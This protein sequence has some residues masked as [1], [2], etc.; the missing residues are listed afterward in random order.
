MA[1]DPQFVNTRRFAVNVAEHVLSINSV[2]LWLFWFMKYLL[3]MRRVPS[4]GFEVLSRSVCGTIQIV[5]V[6]VGE[7]CV[8]DD[9][10]I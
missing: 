2:V 7:T 1:C 9:V 10:S 8:V 5:D 3:G 4:F 6:M